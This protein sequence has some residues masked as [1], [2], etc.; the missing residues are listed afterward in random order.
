[1]R[2]LCIS[3]VLVI[4]GL[5][6]GFGCSSGDNAKTGLP[7]YDLPQNQQNNNDQPTGPFL[8]TITIVPDASNIELNGRQIYKAY[9][10]YSDDAVI[11]ISG[12]V[13]WYSTNMAVGTID[14][15]GVLTASALGWTAI[16]AYAKSTGALTQF[17]YAPYSFAN[18]FSPGQ[19]P[20]TP[21]RNVKVAQV[22]DKSVVTWDFS[23][24]A[25]IKGYNVYSSRISGVGYDPNSPINSKLVVLNHFEDQ[26][27]GD[28]VIYYVVAAVTEDNV[29]GAFSQEVKLDFHPA[30]PGS[31]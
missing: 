4:L 11:D 1:M 30:L 13:N 15:H 18:V 21:V 31:D 26:N 2:H 12:Q 14:D 3:V 23:T 10:V 24:E 9:G 27:P 8:Q 29:I 28:G 19:E 5:A 20:P 16:G 6:L 17:V 25:N 22:G 7:V